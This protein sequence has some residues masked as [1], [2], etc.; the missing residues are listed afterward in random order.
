MARKS[1]SFLLGRALQL[2]QADQV[3]HVE[4][5][6]LKHRERGLEARRQRVRE[7]G[8]VLHG[9]LQAT[10][11]R[12]LEAGHRDDEARRLV[13]EGEPMRHVS[14]LRQRVARADPRVDR[15]RDAPTGDEQIRTQARRDFEL[16]RRREHEIR[17]HAAGEIAA[18][19]IEAE[20]RIV[21][22]VAIHRRWRRA[23]PRRASCLIHCCRSEP[24]DSNSTSPPARSAMRLSS[25]WRY[26]ER[27]PTMRLRT[28]RCRCPRPCDPAR[29]SA[30]CA[31]FRR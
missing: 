17:P 13:H 5:R 1:V 19:A 8:A 4:K 26:S 23:V 24:R 20:I 18:R 6:V 3:G 22:V 31:N 27:K 7:P 25:A 11:E 21:V 28:S 30:R 2:N 15:Q 12:R 14:F 29:A 10:L 16:G 9:A